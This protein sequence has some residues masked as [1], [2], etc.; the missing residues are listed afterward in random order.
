[1]YMYVCMHVCMY[2]CMY[3]YTH[4]V[5]NKVGFSRTCDFETDSRKRDRP[6]H[7]SVCTW[8]QG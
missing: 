4:M 1:M 5:M 7:V 6:V 8:T 2:V 3:V